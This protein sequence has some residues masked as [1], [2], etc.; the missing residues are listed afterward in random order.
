MR[1][2]GPEEPDPDRT[3]PV[4][5]QDH[6]GPR[7]RGDG[8]GLPRQRH[9]PPPGRRD[10]GA[11]AR[12]GAGRRAPGALQARGPPPCRPQPPEDRRHLRA[13]GG[14]WKAL[15]R[16]RA[17]RG[18]GPQGA[19]RAGRDPR[20]RGPRDRQADRGGARGGPQQG[21]RPPGPEAGECEADTRGQGKGPGL[22]PRQGVGG[23]AAGRELR[24][25]GPLAVAHPRPHG[26][27]RGGDPGHRGLHVARAGP[28]QA[29]RQAGRRVAFGVLLWELAG[30]DAPGEVAGAQSGLAAEAE[31]QGR[32]RKERWAWA[33]AATLLGGVAATPRARP[34]A[35][36]AAA[37]AAR[38]PVRRR[39]PGR[40]GRAKRQTP[41]G[42]RTADPCSSARCTAA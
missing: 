29:R 41:C 23:R 26:H 13:R 14:R 31:R 1:R 42:L 36:G 7:S 20:R 5:L 34:A 6:L 12:G 9:E 37:A 30:K 39:S 18:G 10:Q 21:H 8:R 32:R 16:P 27:N 15:P 40:P 3:D 38:G 33:A 35:R 19:A 4:A 17:G 22:R 24:L 2:A 11:A 28:G 25:G